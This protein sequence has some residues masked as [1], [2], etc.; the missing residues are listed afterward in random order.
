MLT[1]MLCRPVLA[2]E[3]ECGLN[4]IDQDDDGLI[5]I[6]YLED[7]NAI[8]YQPDG[9]GYK[10][11]ARADKIT[12]GCR[13]VNNRETCNGY[14]L[15]R[16]LSF[17]ENSS[18]RKIE[19]KS[20]W[21]QDTGWQPIGTESAPFKARFSGNMFTI[22]DLVI[23]SE[24]NAGLFGKLLDARIENIGLLNVDV[25]GKGSVGT[26]AARAI[27]SRII[28]SYSIGKVYGAL[29][30]SSIS[31]R[32]E[33]EEFISIKSAYVGG[34]VGYSLNSII[35]NSYTNASVVADETSQNFQSR[36]GGLIG[37][38]VDSR[39]YNSYAISDV[40]SSR[41]GGGLVG[42]HEGENA[43]IV[44]CYAA[45]NISATQRAGGL[46][47]SVSSGARITNSYSIGGVTQTIG[48][49]SGLVGEL[50]IG[51]GEIEH[52][53]WDIDTSETKTSAG[54]EG[55][56]TKELRSTKIGE[57]I[58]SEWSINDWDSGSNREYPIVKNTSATEIIE[59]PACRD[60]EDT[61]ALLPVCE[62]TLSSQS[63]IGLSSL[64]ILGIDDYEWSPRFESRTFSYQVAFYSSASSIHLIATANS[65]ADIGV[66]K[67]SAKIQ[68]N[69][70]DGS[71]DSIILNEG[72]ETT[73]T[74]VVTAETGPTL[75]YR[76]TLIDKSNFEIG[77]EGNDID[78][79]GDGLIEIR[80]LEDLNAIRYQLSGSSYKENNEGTPITSG[81]P[82]N[83]CIGYELA[84][85]LDFNNKR[86][87]RQ[88][89]NGKSWV[90]ADYDDT[91]NSGWQPIGTMTTP[92]SGTFEGNN[93]T[94]SNL[95]INRDNSNYVGLFGAISR[96]AIVR[97]VGL[98][99]SKIEGNNYVG[100]LVGLND[101]NIVGSYAQGAVTG[102]SFV[103][104]L[105]GDND[106]QI[107]NSYTVSAVLRRISGTCTE[108]S[109][110][111]IGGLAGQNDGTIVNSHS[112]GRLVG[113]DTADNRSAAGGIVGINNNQILNSFAGNIISGSFLAGG[114]VGY[115]VGTIKNSY[116][117]G[118][119]IEG[120]VNN[121]AIGGLAGVVAY[122]SDEQTSAQQTAA[123]LNS[124]SISEIIL[125]RANSAAGELVG[126]GN[127]ASI[128]ERSY[129]NSQINRH[130]MRSIKEIGTFQIN[131]SSPRTRATS[132]WT[133]K[134]LKRSRPSG[135]G[136][137]Y[138][139]WKEED[140]DFG[141]GKQYPQ[142]RYVVGPLRDNSA[143][144]GL[145]CS[146]NQI[147]QNFG[148]TLGVSVDAF[149]LPITSADFNSRFPEYL[150]S[151][152]RGTRS[153]RLTP[154]MNQGSDSFIFETQ[155]YRSRVDSGNTAVVPLN[156]DSNIVIDLISPATELI[157]YFARYRLTV[158][159]RDSDKRLRK[160]TWSSGKWN[161]LLST[162]DQENPA[163]RLHNIVLSYSTPST[164]ITAEAS[165]SS[166][167]VVI[168]I[169]G[170]NS[171]A[172]T[173]GTNEASAKI[174]AKEV[175]LQEGQTKIVIITVNAEDGTSWEHEVAVFREQG[176]IRTH[177]KVFLESLLR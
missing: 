156:G 113:G 164:I 58:Y 157:R 174:V 34:L 145:S 168:N 7:L 69:V 160:L 144:P 65:E 64:D 28:A 41:F 27:Q 155:S 91:A 153:L 111:P 141:T 167:T 137:P 55:K 94:I 72:G 154:T 81:C 51:G 57:G 67:G 21:T 76:I 63:G 53:Y 112:T 142:A 172:T 101:G 42:I 170:E 95:Q 54:G 75:R 143:C 32:N 177:L 12:T 140:W 163:N 89:D 166:A 97:S 108:L 14:E 128:I 49:A 43:Q 148:W 93:Y 125:N 4:D 33:N 68:H 85:N 159:Q 47:G 96:E 19:N 83:K 8:R 36:V 129:W 6:C 1:T 3:L 79:D 173:H 176:P 139:A 13:L 114:L 135:D 130:S 175:K 50:T 100:G 124:Y 120:P 115:S 123:I 147:G 122:R 25:N 133:A 26:L 118:R 90:V 151:V 131:G 171:P 119:V 2:Q 92:F 134:R 35:I 162:D 70:V 99:D 39:I 158:L 17:R 29:L 23:N 169:V 62:L 16:N 149:I 161:R 107:F 84:R 52:S 121:G 109:C 66:Y 86:H 77:E 56:R 127:N 146:G 110:N 106:A 136:L 87:Y 98:Y 59:S 73:V 132:G 103:G 60:A 82:G 71:G 24:T 11:N 150:L 31:Y 126:G 18:Y 105:V 37:D 88:Q 78:Q 117:I 38:N 44:N 30:D 45:G 46:V 20:I 40:I 74:I 102:N 80:F 61:T 116:S 138:S 22:S 9:T 5:E 152:P 104:G 165:H 48:S 15:A 10:A